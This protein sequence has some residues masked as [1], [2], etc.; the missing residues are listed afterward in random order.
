VCSKKNDNFE[1]VVPAFGFVEQF[2]L[3]D[4]AIETILFRHWV[5]VK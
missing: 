4:I 3:N 1:V 2:V 5:S